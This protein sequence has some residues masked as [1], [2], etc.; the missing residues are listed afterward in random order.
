MSKGLRL[1]ISTASVVLIL[2]LLF[3]SNSGPQAAILASNGLTTNPDYF[4]VAVWLQS[5]S[6]AAAYKAT[7]INL[8]IGLWDGPVKADLDQLTTASMPALC[9][10][11]AFAL[12][13]LTA[14][15]NVLAGWTQMDEPDNAQD[16]GAGG[17]DPCISPDTI[18]KRYTTMKKADSTRP[19]FLNLGQAVAYTSWVGRGTC[20]GRT[21]MYPH[22]LQG[23]D[24]GCFDI[25]P[26]NS[27]DAAVTG[28][29]WYVAKGVDSLRMWC[30]DKKP[31][32]A[33][34]ECTSI[35]GGPRPTPAQVKAEVWMAL[36]HGAKGFG[37]FCHSI[38][39]T[40]IEAAW[41]SDMVM[42]PAITA[43]N[44]R[45][46][47]LAPAL[48]GPTITG[49]VNVA[50]SNKSVP[51]D[52]MVKNL[53]GADYVFAVAMRGDTTTARFTIAGQ[54]AKDSAEVLDENR[55]V[56]VAGGT[57]SDRFAG[58]GVHL[59]RIKL[60]ANGNISFQQASCRFGGQGDGVRVRQRGHMI[61]VSRD[62]DASES[63]MACRLISCSGRQYARFSLSQG[64]SAVIQADKVPAGTYMVSISGDKLNSSKLFVVQ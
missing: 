33:W 22:Y 46:I 21:D 42:K 37:Y 24:I 27:T 58:Y 54:S 26:V 64:K 52:I 48:N 16:N 39:P 32:W 17:Y 6:N 12:A 18:I 15:G 13:N 36:I 56:P 44:Q 47:A 50:S 45:I 62:A 20:T 8:Y 34:I 60:P 61:I 23:C 57:F 41:L 30:N 3:H 11:N 10:Q 63:P 7:G 55:A 29:L 49:A 51:V 40:F 38:T 9:D 25:Y 4:P 2:A 53:A 35:N 28:N 31:V 14:Y 1:Q 43:I 19:V 59:Y 5:P